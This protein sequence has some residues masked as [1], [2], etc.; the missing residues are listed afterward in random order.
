[1]VENFP[2]ALEHASEITQ[3]VLMLLAGDDRLVSTAASRA[4]FE[5]M[6]NKRN[7]QIIYPESYHEIFNDLDRDKAV[8]DL[9]KFLNPFLGA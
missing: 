3:P 5:K 2:L 9:K 7:Q 8:A 1:M 4:L 6:P